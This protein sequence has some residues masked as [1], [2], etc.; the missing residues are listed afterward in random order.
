MAEIIIFY[1]HWVLCPRPIWSQK[2][3]IEEI[4]VTN[5]S[6]NLITINQHSCVWHSLKF[7]RNSKGWIFIFEFDGTI[8]NF[9]MSIMSNKLKATDIYLKLSSKGSHFRLIIS[10]HPW[11]IYCLTLETLKIF[12]DFSIFYVN[13][14]KILGNQN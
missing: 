12:V 6:F 4:W 9:S 14:E 8:I 7:K 3:I 11:A 13:T 5:L 2:N 10:R 1:L